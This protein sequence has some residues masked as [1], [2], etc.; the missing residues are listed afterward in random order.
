MKRN[1]LLFLVS[2]FVFHDVSGALFKIPVSFIDQSFIFNS[3]HLVYAEQIMYHIYAKEGGWMRFLLGSPV[4]NE[5]MYSK[6]SKL[7]LN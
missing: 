1:L 5:G 4:R 7:Y 3:G 2:R 6:N